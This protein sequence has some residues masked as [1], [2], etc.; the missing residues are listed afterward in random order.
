[1]VAVRGERGT[2]LVA[3]L[4][5]SLVLVPLALLAFL[6]AN[7]EVTAEGNKLHADQALGLADAGLAVGVDWLFKQSPPP[8]P[9]FNDPIDL[10]ETQFNPFG[11]YQVAVDPDDGND[12]TGSGP[13]IYA[14]TSVGRSA[15]GGER[16]V[17]QMVQIDPLDYGDWLYFFDHMS[18]W[19]HNDRVVGRVYCKHEPWIAKSSWGPIFM[20]RL[21]TAAGFMKIRG[22]GNTSDPA[23][24]ES[25]AHF[26]EGYNLDAPEIDLPSDTGEIEALAQLADFAGGTGTFNGAAD[27]QLMGNQVMVRSGNRFGDQNWHGPFALPDPPCIHVGGNVDVWGVLDGQLCIGATGFIR[28]PDDLVYHEDPRIVPES[29]DKLGLVSRSDFRIGVKPGGG[30][31]IV[32]ARILSMAKWFTEKQNDPRQGFWRFFGSMTARDVGATEPRLDTDAEHDLREPPMG[33]PGT[34]L[35]DKEEYGKSWAELYK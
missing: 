2:A 9:P 25:N 14:I 12:Y 23:I 20:K 18:A 15:F 33:F 34:G 5:L 6:T 24:I 22:H 11:S 21:D 32:Q 26:Y 29:D 28:V 17:H 31:H 16:T 27:F 19:F 35:Y 1:L 30:D 7:V 4:L 10:G 8:Q 13:W 3:V